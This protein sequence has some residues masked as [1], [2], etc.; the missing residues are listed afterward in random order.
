MPF[1][2]GLIRSS[3]LVLMVLVVACSGDRDSAG[4]QP[5][6]KDVSFLQTYSVKWEPGIGKRHI[7]K[8]IH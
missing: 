7:K 6:H 3:W 5:V 1:M 4:T 8:C 2:K